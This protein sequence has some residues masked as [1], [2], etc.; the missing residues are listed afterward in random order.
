MLVTVSTQ[1]SFFLDY[2]L[3]CVYFVSGKTHLHKSSDYYERSPLNIEETLFRTWEL[4]ISFQGSLSIAV[5]HKLNG[6]DTEYPM[7]TCI[8]KNCYVL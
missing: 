4:S 2:N 5:T 6:P 8:L 1:E 7:S 3:K